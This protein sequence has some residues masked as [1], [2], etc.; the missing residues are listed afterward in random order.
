MKEIVKEILEVR[1]C[2]SEN[3]KYSRIAEL[4][5]PMPETKSGSELFIVD[6][7][8]A[9]WK[10]VDYLR[11]WT[12]I[13]NQFDISTG[14]FEIGVLLALDG[15]WQKVEKIHILM[16]DEATKRTKVTLL[17][18]IKQKL[19]DSIEAEKEKNDFLH[20]VSAIIEGIKSGQIDPRLQ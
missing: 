11:E 17:Q 3:A 1:L 4:S 10:V 19:D 2:L 8:D 6:N 5:H 9:E 7:S 20:G 15:H 18:G 12:E 13:S 14:Y 16:G